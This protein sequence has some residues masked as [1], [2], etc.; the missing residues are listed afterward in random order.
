MSRLLPDFPSFRSRL[1]VWVPNS[2]D[3]AAEALH[4]VSAVTAEADA[5]TKRSYAQLNKLGEVEFT[6]GECLTVKKVEVKKKVWNIT[7]ELLEARAQLAADEAAVVKSKKLVADLQDSAGFEEE[8]GYSYWVA[9][10]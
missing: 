2:Y 4:I 8:E 6:T 3:D 7:P 1:K 9:S 5:I 10:K